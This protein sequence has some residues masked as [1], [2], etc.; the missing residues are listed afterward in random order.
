MEMFTN[1]VKIYFN[2]NYFP[3]LKLISFGIQNSLL[4]QIKICMYKFLLLI[5]YL[6]LLSIF[7]IIRTNFIIQFVN[8]NNWTNINPCNKIFVR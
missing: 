3:N 2:S 1:K 7:F 8:E 4:Q 6:L 5:I